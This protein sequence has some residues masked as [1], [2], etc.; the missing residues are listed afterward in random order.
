MSWALASSRNGWWRLTRRRDF[1]CHC[2]CGLLHPVQLCDA[3]CDMQCPSPGQIRENEPAP[4]ASAGLSEARR[5][6]RLCRPALNAPTFTK[7]S[8]WIHQA[9]TCER[10]TMIK[11][12]RLHTH[13]TR[14]RPGVEWRVLE[15]AQR[16]ASWGMTA[17]A[18]QWMFQVPRPR[19]VCH[20]SLIAPQVAAYAPQ[21][22]QVGG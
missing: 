15:R 7:D 12:A 20:E 5:R 14:S 1:W 19:P 4:P 18:C 21:L 9:S 3:G 2:L 16:G 10:I 8:R 22:R 13:P 11:P 17:R 6:P